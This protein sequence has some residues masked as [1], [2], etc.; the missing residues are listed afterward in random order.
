MKILSGLAIGLSIGL[1]GSAFGVTATTVYL[2]GGTAGTPGHVAVFTSDGFGI[3]DGGAAV[4]V[5]AANTWTGINTFGE[6]HTA[7]QTVALVS[8]NYT[9]VAADCGKKKILPTGTSPTVTLPANMNQECTVTFITS[10]AISYTFSQASSGSINSQ[11]FTHS[12]GANANDVISVTVTVPSA[13]AA[14][15][16]VVGDLTS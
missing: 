4:A 14:K 13:T 12:R 5:G 8:N 11:N 3:Q 7:V 10:V 15:W 1:V 9:L 16:A 6:I 2:S